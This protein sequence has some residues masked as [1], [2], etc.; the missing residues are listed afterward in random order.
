MDGS[1]RRVCASQLETFASGRWTVEIIE[2]CLG[3]STPP[4]ATAAMH[5]GHRLA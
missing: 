5:M 1:S 3:Y 4:A 2:N